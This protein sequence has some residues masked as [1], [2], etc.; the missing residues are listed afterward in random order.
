[1]ALPAILGA[2]LVF[3]T[4]A[5]RFLWRRHD[6]HG[7]PPMVPY[8]FPWIGSMISI[9]RDPDRFFRNA[10]TKV[11]AKGIFGVMVGGSTKYYVTD[12]SLI[13]EVYKNAQSFGFSPIRLEYTVAIFGMP[14]ESVYTPYMKEELFAY[15]HRLLAPTAIGSLISSYEQQ[16]L[17]VLTSFNSPENTSLVRFLHPQMYDSAILAF[18]GVTFP[19]ATSYP[20]FLAFD[21]AFPLLAAGF[22]PDFVTS[23]GRKVRS[24][25]TDV[26]Q[27]WLKEHW[28]AEKGERDESAS[29]LVK[30]MVDDSRAAGYSDRDVAGVLLTDL[31]ALQANSTWACFWVIAFMLQQPSG[32]DPLYEE[33]GD[34]LEGFNAKDVEPTSSS[35]LATIL[36]APLPLLTS[37]I[38]ETLR[39]TTSSSSIRRVVDTEGAYLAGYTFEKDD[40]LVC[41][42]RTVHQNAELYE[43]PLVFKPDR[44]LKDKDKAGRFWNPFGG[45]VSMCEGRHFAQQEIRIFIACL[46]LHFDIAL[47]PSSLKHPPLEMDMSRIGLGVLHPKGDLNIQINK[48][49]IA[50]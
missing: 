26:I 48:R 12:A 6:G 24:Q 22:M 20:L 44:Y 27:Q 41:V 45:G 46:L 37:T 40:E 31:W 47:H 38:T 14:H 35:L 5:H 15:H 19:T 8:I 1:M 34:A 39:F 17:R 23:T 33:I 2:V 36:A 9:G 29:D 30:R 13:R 49:N 7:K 25:L 43:D 42:T 32:L 11:G 16:T 10:S 50:T 3:L 28:D 21:N 4:L 18:M